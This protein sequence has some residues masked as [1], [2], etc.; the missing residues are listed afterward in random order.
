MDAQWGGTGRQSAAREGQARLWLPK[1]DHALLWAV[2]EGCLEEVDPA[3]SG[4]Q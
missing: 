3:H 2:R 4:S 1:R